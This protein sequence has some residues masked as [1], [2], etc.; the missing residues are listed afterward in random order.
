MNHQ[1][2]WRHLFAQRLY[3]KGCINQT[4]VKKCEKH[5]NWVWYWDEWY[6]QLY[7]FYEFYNESNLIPPENTSLGEWC[8]DQQKLYFQG[9]LPLSKCKYF[10]SIKEWTWDSKYN[11]NSWTAYEISYQR[12]WWDS[13]VLLKSEVEQYNFPPNK[14]THSRYAWWNVQRRN[15]S[16]LS[17]EKEEALTSINTHWYLNAAEYKWFISYNILL[18]FLDSHKRLPFGQ[19]KLNGINLGEWQRLQRSR[20]VSG[21]TPDWQIEQLESL[22]GWKWNVYE[23][24]WQNNFEIVKKGKSQHTAWCS[25]QR[26]NRH[27]L[28]QR[29]IEQLESLPNW[30]WSPNKEHI[31][32]RIKDLKEYTR[33]FKK[34]PLKHEWYK[35][36]KIGQWCTKLRIKYNKGELEHDIVLSLES[37]KL[38]S[39]DQL[40]DQWL[41]N[42]KMLKGFIQQKGRLPYKSDGSIGQWVNRQ[43]QRRRSGSMTTIQ[44]QR[45]ESLNEWVWNPRDVIWK[46]RYDELV[47]YLDENG[48]F[49]SRSKHRINSWCTLQKSMKRQGKLK[50]E[51]IKMLEN[52]SNWA[53]S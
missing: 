53:W 40:D 34:L 45:L 35:G 37:I 19:E 9:K 4:L 43:H 14:K 33:K 41:E 30:Q 25:T 17:K 47:E 44:E 48:E 6:E 16:E 51:R 3:F 8:A 46:A 2:I 5:S 20:K 52:I 26:R 29:Q 28:S 49:P 24:D 7:A 27:K 15:R 31:E 32:G 18:K 23:V 1:R 21:I 42:F 13:F 36:R 10:N 22:P 39:W 50:P 38:W 12:Q 11:D